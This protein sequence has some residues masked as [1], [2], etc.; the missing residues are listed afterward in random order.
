MVSV[1]EKCAVKN[2]CERERERERGG[3]RERERE[4]SKILFNSGKNPF[5]WAED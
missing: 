3:E 4:Y 1:Y 5:A 2:R